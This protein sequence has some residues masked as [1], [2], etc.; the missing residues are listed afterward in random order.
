MVE[1][2]SLY[3][4]KEVAEIASLFKEYFDTNRN[5]GEPQRSR[6]LEEISKQI[7][8]NIKEFIGHRLD[9]VLTSGIGH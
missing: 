1:Q 7:P 4:P 8:D 3:T 6:L 2:K 5:Y 9:F